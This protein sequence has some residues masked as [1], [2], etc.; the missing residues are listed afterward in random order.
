MSSGM[1]FPDL[2]HAPEAQRPSGDA[3]ES[4]FTTL[5]VEVQP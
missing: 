4:D 3:W 5:T 1:A 2:D